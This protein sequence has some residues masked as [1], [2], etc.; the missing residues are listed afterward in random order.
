[1]TR[2]LSVAA[3][4]SGVL[5]ILS[6]A[7]PLS[8]HAFGQLSDSPTPEYR[9]LSASAAGATRS[10]KLVAQQETID[11]A[12]AAKQRLFA[13]RI[14]PTLPAPGPGR[15]SPNDNCADAFEIVCGGTVTGDTTGD[16]TDGAWP[17]AAGGADEWYSFV[18]TGTAATVSLCGSSYDTAVM[19]LDGCG[20]LVL[21]CNDDYCNLQSQLDVT[22]LTVGNTYLIA[23]GGFAS[24][25]G[26]YTLTL[27]CGNGPGRCEAAMPQPG[28]IEENEPFGGCAPDYSD[29]FNGG[30]GSVPPAFSSIACGQSFHGYTGTYLV[31]GGLVYRDTDWW[32]FDV[33]APGAIVTLTATGDFPILIGIVGQPCPQSAFLVNAI[34]PNCVQTSVTS[35]CLPPGQYAAWIG[36]STYSGVPCGSQYR[37]TLT[38]TPCEPS[39]P[40]PN[41]NCAN[42]IAIACGATVTGSTAR[43]TTD[44]VWPCASGGSDVWYS[45]VA[46]STIATADLCASSNYD[47][48]VMITDG[49]GGIVL[50]CNDDAC[51]PASILTLSNLTVGNTY[52]IVVG[53]FAGGTGDYSMS[54]ICGSPPCV[55]AQ[56][57]PGDIEENESDN[58]GTT[59]G[60]CNA[61][62]PVF[63]EIACGDSI[64]GLSGTFSSGGLQYR[65]TDWWRFEVVEPGAI[66]TW[67][68][69]AEFPVLIGF[70]A[71]PCPATTFLT[72]AIGNTCT[73]T[74]TTSDCLPPG[75]YVAFVAPS[76]FSGVPCPSQYRGSL[77]C[78]PC[79]PPPPP[80]NDNCID[81]L[82]MACGS[83]VS[84][85][86]LRATTD[87]AWSCAAG[88]SD[89]WYSFV[90]TG[91]VATV[92]LC[93]S[94]YDTAV[95]LTDGCGGV[96]LGCNDDACGLRSNL[97]VSNLI[98]GHTYLIAVGG[99]A[100]GTGDYTMSLICEAPPCPGDLDGDGQR[101]LLDLAHLLTH[102]GTPSGAH[103][104]DGDLDRDGDVDLQDLAF[105]LAVFGVPC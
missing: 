70:V 71:L 20:G 31:G 80:A 88:G 50:G 54:L 38:C 98:V 45:F 16:T 30:C 28:D 46:T 52:L 53:G 49:C 37:A 73:E 59:P 86:T 76:V 95:M 63:S 2:D 58:C 101:N 22:G 29:Q 6:I 23:V 13:K 44:G 25:T 97:T 62:P 17:C 42:A 94:S 33:A 24:S 102:F 36:P 89:V 66:A 15:R 41:D 96:V 7:L 43:A 82:P 5:T 85:S 11:P 32:L 90:A 77:T 21:G 26:A 60:G 10:S 47:T 35:T 92:D 12:V 27:T 91:A 57:Q 78:A 74:S 81:A 67:T 56:A 104:E 8:I 34:G 84:G 18:A 55:A 9:S 69:T 48:A 103:P 68:V 100:G 4:F 99:F 75:E 40:P 14:V 64:H 61:N 1:M 51:G 79:Q 65:D 19:V 87:G 105:L 3:R 83:T 72:Y 39:P 93:G